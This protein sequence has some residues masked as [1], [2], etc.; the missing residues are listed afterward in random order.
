[1]PYSRNI[2]R[3]LLKASKWYLYDW[4]R[5]KD[6][7]KR[8]ENYIAVELNSRV[9]AW[10]DLT[11]MEFNLSYIRNKNKQETDFL[12]LKERK[13]WLM[14]EAKYSDAPI[15]SHH[16]AVSNILGGIPVVQVCFENNVASQE[17]KNAFRVSASRL[18]L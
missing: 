6:P 17:K 2:K 11:G 18:L 13:P 8:F 15:E 7:Y 5:I 14:V 3:A 9:S 16:I 1:M 10:Q 4:T 12:I